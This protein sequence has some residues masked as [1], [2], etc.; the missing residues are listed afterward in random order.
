[1]VFYLQS[2]FVVAQQSLLETTINEANKLRDKGEFGKTA[3]LLS[4]FNNKYPGDIWV[5]RLYAETL[6]WMHEY[7]MA[8]TVYE[9]AMRIHPKNMDVKYEYAIMLFDRGDY[10]YSR[11][12]LESYT[13][14][15]DSV[16]GAESLL[17]ISDYY[18]G[19]FIAA[20]KHLGKSL[21]IEAKD[22]RTMEIYTE[23]LHIVRPWL[24]VEGNYMNDSQ[25]LRQLAPQIEAG[26]YKSHLL[27]LSFLLTGRNFYTD[28]INS[29]F[30]N[31]K[32]Q[33]SFIAPKAGFS[34]KVSAG[35]FSFTP[36]DQ[37][38]FTWSVYLKQKIAKR[39]SLIAGAEKSPYTYTIASISNPFTRNIY[40]FSAEWSKNNSWDIKTG[41]IGEFFPD[42]NNVQTFYAWALSPSI[43]FS[44]F[45]LKLGYAF[46]YSNAKENRYVAESSLDHIVDNWVDGQSITGVYDPYFT[47]SDQFSNSVLANLNIKPGKKT[48]IKLYASVGFF[49]RAMNP[50]LYL[51][52]KNSGKFEIRRDFYQES[53][54]P[55]DMGINFNYSLSNKIVLSANY[56][57]LQTFYFNS[58]DFKVGLKIYF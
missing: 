9:D 6:Y 24:K 34:A 52:K 16:A 32:L 46:N 29:T 49:A 8:A 20:E 30:V 13:T 17:G 23:V 37:M 36:F 27:N 21:G 53:F 57:Y 2:N 12:L 44:V 41:Y 31:I 26:F 40:N 54:T 4:D 25:S 45:E 28:S 3:R 58:N 39:I 14:E 56:R 35:L 33:N 43:R 7:D 48:N 50:Y 1:V 42:S 19:D 55:I 15:Y 11:K 10:E 22:S 51:K 18:L 47:P 5:M 38:E